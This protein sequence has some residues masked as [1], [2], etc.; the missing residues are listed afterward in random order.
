MDNLGH[1]PVSY[2][3][4]YDSYVT[5]EKKILKNFEENQKKYFNQK[6]SGSRRSS[7]TGVRLEIQHEED[8]KYFYKKMKESGEKEYVLTQNINDLEKQIN[9]LEKGKK[10]LD[11]L[12]EGN[13]DL[14]FKDTHKK[15]FFYFYIIYLFFQLCK[16]H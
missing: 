5:N 15:V 9:F 14:R 7:N 4:F 11:S 8:R 2:K 6:T 12:E 1:Y 3:N 13:I 16:L 10:K